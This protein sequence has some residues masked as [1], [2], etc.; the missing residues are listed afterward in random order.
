MSPPIGEV[1]CLPGWWWSHCWRHP[2]LRSRAGGATIGGRQLAAR[3]GAP[4]GEAPLLR[5]PDRRG[6]APA[7]ACARHKAGRAPRA[8]L[9]RHCGA[10][11]RGVP[12]RRR[13]EGWQEWPALSHRSPCGQSGDATPPG[14]SDRQHA[15]SWRRRFPRSTWS[16]KAH[17]STTRPAMLTCPMVKGTR[18]HRLHRHTSASCFRGRTA[19]SGSGEQLGPNRT[20]TTTLR[21]HRPPLQCWGR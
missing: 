8:L 13:G 15:P 12:H 7:P 21:L 9:R 6:L 11:P 1:R 19:H 17:G 14:T 4:A 20:R 16:K 10:I 18:H 5:V 2:S 3:R